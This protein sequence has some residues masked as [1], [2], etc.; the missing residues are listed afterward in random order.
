MSKRKK[1]A[2]L[3]LVVL[4]VLSL[5]MTAFARS[6]VDPRWSHFTTVVGDLDISSNGKA[7][8]FA[9]VSAN[10]NKVDKVKVV[11][12]LQRVEGKN[13]K[14]I[15]SWSAESDSAAPHIA[16]VSKTYYVEKGYSYRIKVDSKAYKDNSLQESI[17]NYFEYG[18]FN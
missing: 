14:T 11:C 18:F 13:W 4:A 1:V 15:K 17:T 6:K 7:K 12:S 16:G 10:R 3:F 2:Q 8:V 9:N 5:S